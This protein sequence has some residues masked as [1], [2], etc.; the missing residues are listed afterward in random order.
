[1]YVIL[2]YDISS[3]RAGKVLKLCRMYLNHVQKSVFEGEITEGRLNRL[4]ASIAEVIDPQ[5]DSVII[6]R[7]ESNRYTYKDK[8]GVTLPARRLVIK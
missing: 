1:M 7:A 3:K 5:R 2:T 6:Y 8:I 4:K